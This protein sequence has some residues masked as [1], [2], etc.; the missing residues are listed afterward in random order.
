MADDTQRAYLILVSE[1]M[2]QQTQVAR[3]EVIF[4]RFLREFPSVDVL[5]KASNREV[6][7]AWQGMGYNSRALRLR[8]AAKKIVQ[9]FH[10]VFPKKM[11]DLLAIKGI[12]AYTA[13][14]I[15]NFAFDLPTPCLD[16]NIRRIIHRVFFGAEKRDGTWR[17]DDKALLKTATEVLEEGGETRHWHAALMDFGSLVCTKRSPKCNVCPLKKM[18]K[19][20]FKVRSPLS[21]LRLPLSREPGR[22]IA[23]RFVPNR[24]IRGRI[25]EYLRRTPKRSTLADIGAHVCID[26]DAKEHGGWLRGILEKLV[27]DSLI[28][29]KRGRFVL[30]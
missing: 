28:K 1:V 14:A 12:G 25:V 21:A 9:E 24:I 3:V 5:A 23:G 27:S 26:W 19:A 30:G 7:L 11:E 16:T 13:A 6:I 10:G 2:L 22:E 4:K 8:D 20:A 18:C 17:M 29:E 15:R